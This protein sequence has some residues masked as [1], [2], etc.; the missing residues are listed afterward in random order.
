MLV[1]NV[2]Q[3]RQVIYLGKYTYIHIYIYTY[4]HVKRIVEK[5]VKILKENVR[6]KRKREL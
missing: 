3:T 1:C 4:V 2:I 6:E 5:E